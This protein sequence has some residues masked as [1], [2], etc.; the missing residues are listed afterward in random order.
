MSG[1]E[2]GA[3][4]IGGKIA[5][6]AAKSWLQ[7]WKDRKTRGL[8]LVELAAGAGPLGQA[9]LDRLLQTIGTQVATELEPVLRNEYAALPESEASAVFSAVEDALGEVDLSDDALLA[10]DADE[11]QLARQVRAQCPANEFLSAAGAALYDV[12]LDQSCRQLVLIVRHLPSFQPAALV[13]VLKRLNQ[14]SNQM[15]ELLARLPKTSL[16]EAGT[17]HA[18][19]RNEY[20]RVLADKLDHLELLG[21]TMEDQPTLPLTVAYLSLS[22][23][24]ETQFRFE[25]RKPDWFDQQPGATVRAEN[26]I[27]RSGRTLVRGEAGS[28]KTTLLDWLAVTAARSAFTGR[29]AEWNGFVPFPIRLRSLPDGPLPDADDFVALALHTMRNQVPPGWADEVLRSGEAIVLVDGVD[30]VQP[31]QRRKV[32]SWLRE[33]GAM[34]PAAR[35]V[36]TSR[37]AAADPHWLGSE[38]FDSVVLEPMTAPDIHTL[39]ERW[40]EAAARVRPNADLAAAERRLLSQLDNRPHLRA[41]AANP[42]LCAMLCALNLTRRSELP[43]DRMTLYRNA[44]SMLVHSRDDERGIRVLLTEQQKHVLLGHLAWRLTSGNKVELPLAEVREHLEYRLKSLPNVGYSTDEVVEHLVER[45]AVLRAPAVGRIDFVHR[46]FQEYLAASEA[47]EAGYI[48]ML[49]DNAHRDTWRE[50]VVM[51]CGHAKHHQA[52]KLL[53]EIMDRADSEPRRARRLRLLAAACL[54]TVGDVDPDVIERVRR[55]IREHLVPPRSIVEAESLASVGS[56]LLHYLPSALDGLSDAVAHATTAAATM[57]AGDEVLPLLRNYAQDERLMVQVRLAEAWNHF[58]PVRYVDEV[59]ADSPLIHGRITVTSTRLIPHV[60][61]LKNLKALS[62]YIYDTDLAVI[63]ETPALSTL[64]LSFSSK[65]TISL[66]PLVEHEGLRTLRL[67]DARDYTDVRAL[68]KLPHLRNLG[69]FTLRPRRSIRTFAALPHLTSLALDNLSA[70]E[71]LDALA[72]IENLTELTL[73]DCPMRAIVATPPLAQVRKLEYYGESI[74]DLTTF[75]DTFPG[76]TELSLLYKSSPDLEPLLALPLQELTVCTNGSLQSLAAHPTLAEL[77]VHGTGESIDLSP[78]K[79][80]KLKLHVS[81]VTE[82]IGVDQ[83][84]PGV[85]L[86]R[87]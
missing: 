11:E 52:T 56:Q 3:V 8:S 65:Q 2:A 21:L 4:K 74:S 38:R 77:T 53:K 84:G 10:A 42:L 7:R 60:R 44:L 31:A 18:Q 29:L 63:A 72:A 82:L 47:T 75:A 30:E 37:T 81:G 69:L 12:A 57:C 70:I 1:L 19:F 62:A 49:V 64:N 22:V 26:A 13:E 76:L 14:Q 55:A 71:S 87:F 79:G 68:K 6:H 5:T 17:D 39:V 54:E 24:G 48:D 36:V 34:Y 86:E 25:S 28:G 67:Y 45:S 66:T 61:R 40:H 9:N 41:L 83:L 16:T 85:K 27:H 59:L 50:T 58:D 51:A 43:R 23:S 15:E 20:L 80:C 46:T 35:I 73:H 33:L 32:K 78:L